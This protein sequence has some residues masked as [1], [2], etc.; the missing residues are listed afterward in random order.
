MND[1]EDPWMISKELYDY[2]KDNLKEGSTILELGSGKGTKFLCEHYKVYSVEHQEQWLGKSKSIYIHAPLINGWYDVNIL[3][4]NL[5]EDYDLL[6]IDGPIG[7]LARTRF[8]DNSNLF[9]MSKIVIFDDINRKPEMEMFLH[10]A[11]SRNQALIVNG[12]EKS[13]GVLI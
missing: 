7:S 1:F 11:K 4:E 5:P 2:I 8:T 13:F 10:F 9:D 12:S 6:L 3:E